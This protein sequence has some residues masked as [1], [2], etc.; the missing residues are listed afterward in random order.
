[1]NE[2]K[3][4]KR[5]RGEMSIRQQFTSFLIICHSNNILD[6]YQSN[7]QIIENTYKIKVVATASIF[8]KP[9]SIND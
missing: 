3:K 7:I 8:L 5:K 4:R 1:M 2:F 6:Q 9:F